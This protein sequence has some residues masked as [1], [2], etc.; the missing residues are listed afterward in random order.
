MFDAKQ[1]KQLLPGQHLKIDRCPGLRLEATAKHHTWTYRYKSPVDGGMKQIKLGR[2]PALSFAQAMGEWDKARQQ[3]EQG[4][5]LALEA[6]SARQTA[7]QATKR[8][9]PTHYLVSQCVEAYCQHLE[10]RRKAR[11]VQEMRRMFNT[12]LGPLAEVNVIEVSRA[13]AFSL[14]ESHMDRPAITNVLRQELAAAWNYA[15]DAGRIPEETPNWWSRVMRGKKLKSKGRKI[16]G[17]YIGTR[18]R[19]L[20]DTELGQLFSFLPNFSLAVQDVLLLYLATGCRGGEI[21]QI[22]GSEITEENGVLWWIVPK[23]KTKNAR[24]DHATDLRVPLWGWGREIVLARKARYGHGYLFPGQSTYSKPLDQEGIAAAVRYFMPNS[25]ARPHCNRHRLDVTNW[26]PHDLRRTVRTGLSALGCHAD[27]AEAVLGHLPT[28]IKGV[29]DRHNYEQER[30]LWLK[31]WNEHLLK[32]QASLASPDPD[33][34]FLS[35]YS[36]GAA[37]LTLAGA[38]DKNVT[39]SAANQPDVE[40]RDVA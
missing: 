20:N 1:A 34:L 9:S 33:A 22:E 25:K 39:Q 3:R 35:R 40:T 13:I 8:N 2:W 26:S 12:M 31:K 32:L 6:R 16:D 11:S 30:V 37:G 10:K 28:G 23:A 29:Y 21:V 15:L 17:Q 4:K 18:R 14:L 27:V 19:V 24:F 7:K 5:D 36:P 38:E